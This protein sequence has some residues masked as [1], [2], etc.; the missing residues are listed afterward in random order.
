MS[1]IADELRNACRS[2]K[3]GDT[4]V[5]IHLFGIEHA[6]RLKG[7]DLKALAARAG[8]SETYGTELRKGVR[9][10]DYVKI[11]ERP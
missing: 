2:A 1:E 4:V 8:I 9:L 11:T 7:M 5:T 3:K 10:A 6:E